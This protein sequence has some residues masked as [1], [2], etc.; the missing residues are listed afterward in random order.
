[1]DLDVLFE[2]SPV[3]DPHGAYC[4]LEPVGPAFGLD[5]FYALS[6]SMNAT[7]FAEADLQAFNRLVVW[8]QEARA[9]PPQRRVWGL[10][11]WL[12]GLGAPPQRRVWGLG[13]WL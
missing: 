1:M 8:Q 6:F 13:F 5:Y 12:Q 10:G 7:S 4:S 11:F 2:M 3:N 9:R